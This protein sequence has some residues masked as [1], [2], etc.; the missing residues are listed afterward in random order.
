MSVCSTSFSQLTRAALAFIRVRVTVTLAAIFS[1][2]VE[3]AAGQS[4]AVDNPLSFFR[5]AIHRDLMGDL[6]AIRP[7]PLGAAEVRR[8]EA[9]LPESG[10]LQPTPQEAQKISAVREIL[11]F[12]DR[13]VIVIKVIDVRQAVVGL[14]ARA[15][16]LVS[17]PA[18]TL[19]S[20]TELRAVAAHEIG[21]DFFWDEY[22]HLREHPDPRRRRRLELRCDGVAV[23]T[24]AALN[25]PL[26]PLKRRCESSRCSM[27]A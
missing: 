20:T 14:H 10:E 11:R 21:H 22:L 23:V 15:V 24:L 12:H 25:S 13:D 4:S 27:K 17:R 3:A 26:R 6:A 16:L 19:L 7:R 5:V 18:L 9:L 8:V 2:G 1:C